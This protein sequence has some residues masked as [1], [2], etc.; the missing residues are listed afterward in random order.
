MGRCLTCLG[1]LMCC[2]GSGTLPA[3]CGTAAGC[4]ARL[5][6]DWWVTPQCNAACLPCL[7]LQPA[8]NAPV[9]GF[10]PTMHSMQPA[11][12]AGRVHNLINS[13]QYITRGCYNAVWAVISSNQVSCVILQEVC[14]CMAMPSKAYMPVSAPQIMPRQR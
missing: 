14:V 10:C 5:H 13:I 6:N 1:T 12:Y 11:Q 8:N 7:L 4:H 9:V 2:A 3:C